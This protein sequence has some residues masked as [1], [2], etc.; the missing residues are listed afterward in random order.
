MLHYVGLTF[1]FLHLAISV[2]NQFKFFQDK[3]GKI[4]KAGLVPYWSFFAPV[5]GTTDHRIVFR[6]KTGQDQSDWQEVEIYEERRLLHVLWN[7]AKH[8]QKC[9]SDASVHLLKSAAK[10]ENDSQ[11]LLQIN[12]AY[13]KFLQLVNANIDRGTIFRFAIVASDGAVIRK[14]SPL[15]ISGWHVS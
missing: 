12:W 1:L 13:I 9:V 14:M 7:P 4:N 10:C 11:D 15:F 8:L 3:I 6:T 2:L 5:P